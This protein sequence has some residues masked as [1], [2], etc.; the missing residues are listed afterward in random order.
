MLTTSES[1]RIQHFKPAYFLMIL[2]LS[3]FIIKNSITYGVYTT[4]LIS[5]IFLTLFT[6]SPILSLAFNNYFIIVSIVLSLAST[7]LA[8]L[9]FEAGGFSA[10]GALWVCAIPLTYFILLGSRGGIV[11]GCFTA[12]VFLIYYI[13]DS[14]NINGPIVFTESQYTKERTID[15]IS[16]T[17]YIFSVSYFFVT[18]EENSKEQLKRISQEIENLL[19]VVVHDI[20][21]PVSISILSLE[22]L[23]KPGLSE[24]KKIITKNRLKN[25]LNSIT[26]ILSEVRT[27]K[28]IRD[29]KLEL[30]VAD[31]NL[32]EQIQ[33]IININETKAEAK[34]I[35]LEYINN[36]NNPIIKGNEVAINNMIISNFLTNAIK[37]SPP[38]QKIQIS[39]FENTEHIIFT[40]R[41]Y[42]IGI[43]NSILENIWSFNAVTSRK[44]TAGESGT[45]Y[46]MPIAKAF[47][48]KMGAIITIESTTIENLSESGKTTSLKDS[49]TL[50]SVYFKKH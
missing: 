40:I 6:L 50:I 18:R 43:P 45:G 27:L 42:G 34:N 24:D 28:S 26:S 25:A 15:L 7:S 31:I 29:G 17:V 33:K 5:I 23:E 30:I 22:I 37:F 3:F 11:G 36:C 48:D 13:L 12:I 35:Q 4:S 44:G 8:I 20:A 41:D 14:F 9:V 39:I 16:F 47:V 46:G 32:D 21:N 19:R 10:P 49:G 2:S 38:F 1:E